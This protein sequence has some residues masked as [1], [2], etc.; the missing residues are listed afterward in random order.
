MNK[1]E[2]ESKLWEE[3]RDL[4]SKYYDNQL[5]LDG[6][7]DNDFDDN[8]DTTYDFIIKKFGELNYM[9]SCNK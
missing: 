3:L 7:K 8:V 2:K 9:Q 4:M 5:P 1:E 6:S